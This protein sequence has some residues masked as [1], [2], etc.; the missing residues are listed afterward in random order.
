[1]KP[2][3][4]IRAL[5]RRWA[6]VL[7]AVLVALGA[8]YAISQ[9]AP[10]G[11]V[12]HTYEATAVILD[13]GTDSATNLSTL[14]A[15]ATVGQVPE[16]VVEQLDL[17]LSPESLA[18]EVVATPNQEA[19][20]LTITATSSDRDQALKVANA[21]AR[22]LVTFFASEKARNASTESGQLLG[23]V[24]QLEREVADLDRQIGGAPIDDAS[25]LTAQRDAKVRQYGLLYQ[26]YQDLAGASTSSL[27]L[28]VIADDTA[29]QVAGGGFTPPRSLAWRLALA[30]ILGLIAG[31]VLVLFLDRFDG[32]LRR[33][34]DAEKH[35]DLSVIAEVP[36]VP[37]RRRRALAVAAATHPKSRIADSYRI[38]GAMLSLGTNGSNGNGN[39]NGNGHQGTYTPAAT[40]P[41]A[42]RAILI[43]S[44]GPGDGKT[45]VAANLAA[46][47]A[48]RGKHV[49]VL[50]CD[51]RRPR[52]HRL[53]G[54]PNSEGLTEHLLAN[55]SGPALDGQVVETSIPNVDLVPC[56]SPPDNP[57]ELLASE[58]MKRLIREARNAA[59]VV[60]IDTAPILT[61][62]DASHLIPEA[63]A[64]VVV[65]RAGRT[66]SEIAERT[67][68]LLKGLDAPVVGVTLNAATEIAL[69]R[70]YYGYYAYYRGGGSGRS[71]YG[72][73]KSKGIYRLA[74][75]S[76]K[77]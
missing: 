43:T 66:T 26:A 13:T 62:S 6:D 31:I 34:V 8:G 5:R 54:A 69:P 19:G 23:R 47:F 17:H 53:L 37:R 12:V 25:V 35:F 41:T 55:G 16:Q 76:R 40:R 3:E 72:E 71:G 67:S 52:I 18:Q 75:L 22:D 11:P 21:Y 74:R 2:S 9:A 56:G 63:D 42:P 73:K 57:G 15:L 59:D 7:L 48:E 24:N 10:P 29:Q 1:M 46:S 44:P 27:D 32:R 65:A 30:G 64:V 14:A 28:Q 33:R 51:F 4:Y 39:G 49:I 45:T 77:G 50:S 58:G 60:V 20:L 68:V 36:F 61:T 38:L 70:R